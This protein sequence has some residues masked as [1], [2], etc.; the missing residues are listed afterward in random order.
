M[1][2]RWNGIFRSSKNNDASFCWAHCRWIHS[3]MCQAAGSWASQSSLVS[4]LSAGDPPIW[5]APLQVSCT[6]YFGVYNI[7]FTVFVRLLWNLFIPYEHSWCP[8]AVLSLLLPFLLFARDK[9]RIRCEIKLP[10]LSV[11]GGTNP[12][13]FLLLRSLFTLDMSVIFSRFLQRQPPVGLNSLGS[14]THGA[15][16]RSGF[17]FSETLQWYSQFSPVLF[18]ITGPPAPLKLRHVFAS[19][20]W[21]CQDVKKEV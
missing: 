11:R 18:E 16:Y 1:P 2:G 9:V 8:F 13:V 5:G 3:A 10:S 19:K 20:I 21:S 12:C 4:G 15:W 17:E 14:Q 6:L 7:W